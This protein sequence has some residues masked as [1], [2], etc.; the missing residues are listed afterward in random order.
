MSAIART[1]W[2]TWGAQALQMGT[3]LLYECTMSALRVYYEYTMGVFEE[4]LR[5]SKDPRDFE[6]IQ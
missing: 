2:R 3:T 6:T 5:V 4:V 1:A